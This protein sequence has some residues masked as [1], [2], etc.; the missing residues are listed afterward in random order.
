MLQLLINF[1]LLILSLTNIEAV[2]H[3]ML[4][5]DF[6]ISEHLKQAVILRSNEQME[7]TFHQKELFV[8]IQEYAVC[9][10][11]YPDYF[12]YQEVKD[13][14]NCLLHSKGAQSG[15]LVHYS[16]RN[17]VLKAFMASY[18]QDN[19]RY[20]KIQSWLLI[21]DADQFNEHDLPSEF[22]YLPMHPFTRITVAIQ[23]IR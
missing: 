22:D 15:I 9:L 16:T 14:R 20:Q 13:Q 18:L 23:N 6:L 3:L 17:A 7:D 21:I 8:L 12:T 10:Y 4:F 11:S 1:A 19:Q 2:F 5:K